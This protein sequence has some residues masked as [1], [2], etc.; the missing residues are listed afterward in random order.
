VK[1]RRDAWAAPGGARGPE[2][3]VVAQEQELAAGRSRGG[4]SDGGTTWRGQ[5]R[6]ARAGDAAA[7]APGRHVAR[8][9]AARG[10]RCLAH[11]RRSGGGVSGRGK[12]E[13]SRE[14]EVDEGLTQ[15]FPKIQGLHCK[16]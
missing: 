14:L 2:E 8:F 6:P 10:G 3:G 11:G 15:N 16:V 5:E 13:Q 12:S 4:S 9:R 1:A 7:L